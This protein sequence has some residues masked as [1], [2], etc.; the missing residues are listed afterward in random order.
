MRQLPFLIICL[1]SISLLQAQQRVSGRIIDSKTSE[2]LPFA[3]IQILENDSEHLSRIDGSFELEYNLPEITLEISYLSYQKR[4][5]E[6]SPSTGFLVI[7]LNPRTE[8]FEPLFLKNSALQAE[9][10]MRKAIE[11]IPKNDPEQVL[12]GF[13]LKAHNKLIVDNSRNLIKPR[14]DP[15]QMEIREIINTA[16]AY[17][18]EKISEISFEQGK[19]RKENVLALNNFGFKKP[20]YEVLSLDI[21]PFSLYQKNYPLFAT[22]YA[23]PLSKAALRNYSYK[24][25]DTTQ[26]ERPAYI[27]YFKPK[28]EKAVAGLEGVLYLDTLSYAIQRSKAQLLGN[29]KLESEQIYSYYPEKDIWIPQQQSTRIQPGLG[30]NEIS[31]FGGV[32]AVGTLQQQ[33]KLLGKI[34]TGTLPEDELF[35]SSETR[36]YDVDLDYGEGIKNPSAEIEVLANAHSQTEEFWNEHRQIDFTSLDTSRAG[37]VESLLRKRKTEKR[38]EIKNRVARGYFPVGFWE[39]D[40]GKFFK[41]NIY[42]GIRLGAGGQTNDKLSRYF[43]LNGYGVYGF[44]DKDF[45]YGY[46][47]DVPIRR[48]SGTRFHFNFTRDIFEMGDYEYLRGIDEF[49]ILEPRFANITSFYFDTKWSTSITHRITSKLETEIQ[50]SNSQIEQ[51]TRYRF[52]YRGE[53]LSEYAIS[54]AEISVLWRPFAKFIQLPQGNN[55]IEKGF[56]KLT[57]QF[58]KGFSGIGGS[59]FDFS[60]MGLKLEHEIRRLDLSRTEFIIEGNYAFGDLPLTHLFHA[61]PNNPEKEAILRRFVVAGRTSFETMY[62]NEFFSD[63]QAMFHL[64]HQLR[65]FRISDRIR[66]ELVLISRH[67]I[68]DI[69][70]K[71]AHQNINFQSLRHGY[72]EAGLELNKI[73]AGLGL[74]AAYR[75]GAYHLPSFDQNFSFKF[76]F[77]LEI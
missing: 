61:F 59:D 24:I 62:Y 27:I 70:N 3:R 29:I 52:N 21:N 33:N 72:S 48:A 54:Q 69:E 31:V 77:K 7:K 6:V 22:Q 8:E 10:I 67:A 60:K 4:E 26:A 56:P 36:F 1:F 2:P 42:E 9:A 23:G 18:S 64:R 44:G 28:R 45:K 11:N 53:N 13:Q 55:L 50:F 38:I 12:S 73:I 25:L 57:A 17:F 35:L 63:R 39:F 75:Y 71:E 46:G 34:L 5:V 37:R 14:A 43:R 32:I 16:A 41:Y 58:T 65:P 74:S 76:T 68:G 66:P 40:L 47:F 51:L 19:G 20:A 15:S 49:S 30:G